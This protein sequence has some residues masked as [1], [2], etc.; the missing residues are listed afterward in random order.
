MISTKTMKMLVAGAALGLTASAALAETNLRVFVSSQHRPDVWRKAFDMYQEARPDVKITIETGGNTSEQQAQYLNTVMTAKD[1]S[2]DVMILDVIRPAQYAAAGWT[3]PFNAVIGGDIGLYMKSY[4]PAYAEANTV[5]GKVV[6]LPAFADA[7]FLYYRKDLLEKHGVEPP[8]T[9][10]ELAAAA[11]KITAAENDPNLQGLSFQGKAIEGAVCTFLLPYWSMGKN[12]VSEGKLTFDKEAAVKALKLWKDFVD[13]GVAKKNIAEVATDDTRK[14]FQ[15]GNVVFAVNWSYAWGQF[16][17][18]ESAV[19]DKVGVVKLPAVAGGEPVSCLGGWE[20]GVSAYSKNATEAA[21][22]VQF[23][24]SPKI[25]KF[26]AVNA[27]LLPQFP[28]VYTDPE[29]TKAVPWFAEAK[30]VVET[31]RARPV[32]PRYN[33]VSEIIRTTVNAVLAGTM[34]PED[35]ASQM[36]ARLRRVLR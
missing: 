21:N 12:L 25:S 6:A 5:D 9:W 24:S 32:T 36:E 17:G 4:L 22:F 28:E 19:K 3:V 14:E 20:W 23:L 16:Q 30:P 10:D 15:A 35:G 7:M 33:E 11:K 31:A 1:S 34:T 8:T 18:A 2:L 13:A 26:M 29:V 27:A